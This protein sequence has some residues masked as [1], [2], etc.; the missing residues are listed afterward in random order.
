MAVQNVVTTNVE[1][2]SIPPVVCKLFNF[3]IEMNKHGH[4]LILTFHPPSGIIEINFYQSE[5]QEF[6]PDY[7][8]WFVAYVKKGDKQDMLYIEHRVNE[9]IASI[10]EIITR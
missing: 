10:R 7:T 9:I 8:D 3:A 1:N 2:L 5:S 4:S 6:V